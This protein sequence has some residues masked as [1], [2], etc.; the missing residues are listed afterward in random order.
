[1]N[2]GGE[3]V[4]APH[5]ASGKWRTTTLSFSQTRGQTKR[6]PPTFC[7]LTLGK[8]RL[9]WRPPIDEPANVLLPLSCKSTTPFGL[10]AQTGC[11]VTSTNYTP[12]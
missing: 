6:I 11:S 3:P 4:R 5:R 7:L 12:N 9:A 10:R 8:A 1:M 2:L